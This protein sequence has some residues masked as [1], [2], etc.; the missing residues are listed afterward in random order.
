[1][2][3]FFYEWVMRRSLRPVLLA[4][5]GGL[6]LGISFP[7]FHQFY[8][9]PLAFVCLMAALEDAK[10]FEGPR[11][12]ALFGV[13]SYLVHV[14][15]FVNFNPLALPGVLL[16]VGFYFGVWGYLLKHLGTSAWTMGATWMLLQT[17][18]GS[19]TLAF[20][21]SRLATALAAEP[22]LVQPVH[23][24]G[25]VLY[26]GLLVLVSVSLYH[27]Y[28]RRRYQALLAGGLVLVIVLGAGTWRLRTI[29]PEPVGP[30]VLMVQP[31]VRSTFGGPPADES[32]REVLDR[33]TRDLSAGTGLIV[34]PETA[35]A[36]YP[37]RIRPGDGTLVYRTV[38]QRDRLASVLPDGYELLAGMRLYDPKP[39]RL[40]YLN[41]AVLLDGDASPRSFYTKRNMVPFGEKIPGMGQYEWIEKLG[42]TLGTLGYRS[43]DVGGLLTLGEAFDGMRAAVQI[44]FEDAFPAY[45][46]RQVR[47]GADLLVNIS[48]DSWSRSSA[49]HWQHF[50]R[51]RLR[52]V[53]TGRTVLRNGNTGVSAVISPLGTVDEYLAPF[54]RGVLRGRVFESLDVPFVV[55]HRTSV[56]VTAVLALLLLGYL[57][58]RRTL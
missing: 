3:G 57:A 24:L 7:P 9:I 58:R 1:M 45:V 26:G 55:E 23:Y 47:S 32:Q 38:E 18:I 25:E 16:I 19:G 5:V 43:G 12:T 36:R 51:A 39:N 44:C 17:V 42:R 20:P 10:G 22:L 2:V 14:Y 13:V 15:W 27:A 8:C 46:D 21:W 48:N 11:R 50:Y 35:L 31:N 52:A 53:E 49:S 40:D 28:E 34:W 4:G 33:L 41:G 56:N 37:F 6:L 30:E 29:E 54:E